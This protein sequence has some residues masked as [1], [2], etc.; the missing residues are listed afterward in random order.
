PP[1]DLARRA[2]ELVAEHRGPRP[3]PRPRRSVLDLV[4]VVVPFRWADV[5]V[6]AGIFLAS[7]IT[8]IPAVQRSQARLGQPRCPSNL[9]RLGVPLTQHPTS[10]GV[11]PYVARES[12]A[13]R[14][15]AFAVLL[16]E[17][18]LLPDASPL[19]CPANG[20]NHLGGPLPSYEALCSM[21]ARR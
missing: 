4:P 21:E 6:A 13:P 5:A 17:A 11:F 2:L 10:Q 20:P 16:H 12:P 7:L 15:G 19:D 9:Q 14:A 3:R 1:P 8:L 18:G